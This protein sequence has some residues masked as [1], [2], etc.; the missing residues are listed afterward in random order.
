MNCYLYLFTPPYDLYNGISFAVRAI[1][2]QRFKY[3]WNPQEVN[4][5]YDLEA[6]PHELTNRIDDPALEAEQARLRTEIFLW[7]NGIGD[8]LPGRADAL[9]TAGTILATD[10]LGP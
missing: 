1:R 4:E 7:M 10:K 9:P 6:D 5:L 8:D 3:V 2:D